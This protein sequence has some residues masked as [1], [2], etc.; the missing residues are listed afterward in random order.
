MKHNYQ[1]IYE[2]VFTV[3][4]VL[5]GS[6]LAAD[7]WI[8]DPLEISKVLHAI[9]AISGDLGSRLQTAGLKVTAIS[10]GRITKGDVA[11]NP[12]HWA[13]GDIELQILTEGDPIADG[14]RIMG[15]PTLIKRRGKY[16][17][18]D[19]TGVW[20]LTGHCALPD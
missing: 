15:S 8:K 14:C 3:F 19:R 12:K 10:I 18:Q 4:M 2:I 20:L 17:P 13:L 9:P 6:A 16:L 11:E 1:I 5:G 7:K